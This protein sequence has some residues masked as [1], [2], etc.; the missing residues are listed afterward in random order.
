M[1]NAS[2]NNRMNRRIKNARESRKRKEAAAAHLHQAVVLPAKH[3]LP[4]ALHHLAAL[5]QEEARPAEVVQHLAEGHQEV[6]PV[7]HL[8]D[9]QL[10]LHQAVAEVHLLQEDH[11]R[12]QAEKVL[13]DGAVHRKA[14]RQKRLDSYYI[15]YKER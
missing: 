5:L 12:R 6:R 13:Q 2:L 7:P 10:G 11:L 9:V 3:L 4:K 1:Q 8:Q 14:D 15:N